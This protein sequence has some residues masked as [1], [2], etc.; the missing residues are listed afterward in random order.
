MTK[1]VEIVT[2]R[3]NTGCN[4][5]SFAKAA[6]G[7]EPFLRET[8]GMI[9]RTLSVDAEGLWT[10]HILWESE[11]AAQ[12]AA[13]AVMQHPSAATMMGMID[14]PSAKMRH[15]ALHLQQQE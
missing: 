1:T 12:T 9:H 11:E 14:G 10:D 5:Q 8:G 6:A 2:F 4:A 13:T 15:A 3:L 7:I